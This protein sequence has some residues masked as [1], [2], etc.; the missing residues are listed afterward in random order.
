MAIE[1]VELEKEK[2]ILKK[3]SHLV[4]K[5]IDSLK[6]TVKI[7]SNDLVEF[8][9][10]IWQD[11][12]SFDA[13][14]ISQAKTLSNEEEHRVMDK[15]KY[16][17]SLLKVEKKP[18][19]ASIVF[20]D[21]DG[22]VF[23]IYLSL[24]YLKDKN[25][26]NILYDWRSPI[27]SL[28]YDY[29][30]GKCSYKAPAGIIE[31]ELLR[32]RQYQIE[33]NRL[34]SVFDN[35][36]N[37]ND[38]VLQT[39]LSENSSEKMKNIVNT[40]QEEQNKI[41]RNLDDDNLI[42]QGI[43][44]SGKTTVALHRIAFLL[45]QIKN[46]TSSNILIFSP[47]NIFTEYISNVLPELG[48]ENTLQTTFHDYLASFLTEYKE[49]ETFS[50]FL[51]RYYSKK[52]EHIKLVKYK[53]SNE[54]IDDFDH[55]LESYIKNAKFTDDIE[56]TKFH[57]TTLEELN[58]MLHYKYD[59]LPLFERLDQ[60][61]EKLSNTFYKGT[62]KKKATFRKLINGAINFSEDYKKIYTDF[63][64][65]D[66]CK[67]VLSDAEIKSFVHRDVIHYEDSLLFTYMK[68]MLN[69]FYYEA[70]VKQVVIDEAQDYNKLQYIIINHIFKKAEFTILGDVNQNINPYYKYSSLEELRDIFKGD[71]RYLELTKTY[72]SSPEIIDYTNKILGL[73]HVSA[74][75]KSSN[76]PIQMR[77]NT[78]DLAESLYED[79][80]TLTKKYQSVAVITKDEVEAK[81]LYEFLKSRLNISLIEETTTNFNKDLVVIPAY[82]AK[83]LEF[84]SVIIYNNRKN[85]YKKDERNLLYVAATRAQHEL[86]IYN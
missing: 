53:Q 30:V 16:L 7:S 27:C 6:E 34:I 1:G 85:S 67:I 35:D 25:L 32:K 51:F 77:K 43:A 63:Y 81:K 86:Y 31:G 4:K 78:E 36:L 71:T 47:N 66:Y 54:I 11:S 69:G 38:E 8:K 74:I 28:F 49:V 29:E 62:N 20:Q 72:R 46:L 17:R 52:E 70:N 75:R 55:Y 13:G 58:E 24:T 84:D 33:N 40:I 68:G 59:R 9:K 42:V 37:I 14:D 15:E 2:T 45:Y 22:D 18:Y 44:G 10:I 57:F 83:G 23:N 82:I 76:V 80:D 48:E 60:I 41:I 61:A 39:V 19:F 50:N 12:S 21:L 5:N 79:I 26:N 73:N 3:V 65:S 56:E 64:K